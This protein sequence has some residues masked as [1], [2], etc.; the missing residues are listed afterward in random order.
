[1]T[2][3]FIAGTDTNVG[4]T[5]VSAVVTMVLE[6]Y[7]WKPVQSGLAE[8][9]SD[10]SVIQQLTGLPDKHFLPCT[11]EFQAPLSTDH[12]AELENITVDLACFKLN[13]FSYPLIAEAA[14]GI[15]VPLNDTHSNMDLIEQTGLPVIVV[16]R[17][18]LGTINHTLLTVSA[19][20]QR[21]IPIKG[22]VFSGEL[23]PL[24]QRSLERWTGLKTLFHVPFMQ[25]LSK[26]ALQTWMVANRQTILEA[27]A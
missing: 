18:T 13:P 14:G 19:L 25:N 11:Y 5:I 2:G 24:N 4:K 27:L 10:R 3:F 6:G 20:K 9:P 23:K 15:M 17:G 16:S 21:N 1:M 12:A 7:Y 22:I 8:F 26:Q